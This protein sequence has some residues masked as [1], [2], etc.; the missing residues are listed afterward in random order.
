MGRT[1]LTKPTAK[2]EFLEIEDGGRPPFD[3]KT[4]KSQFVHNHLTNFNR[5]RQVTQIGRLNAIKR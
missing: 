2:I 5:I 1:A 3:L 4:L